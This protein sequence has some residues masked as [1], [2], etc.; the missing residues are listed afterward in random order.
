MNDE[1]KTMI[2]E[3]LE[4][5]A[6]VLRTHIGTAEDPTGEN[7]HK[8]EMSFNS[9]NGL[10]VIYYRERFATVSGGW[11]ALVGAACQA[12]DDELEASNE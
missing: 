12:I 6:L 8:I 3:V 9:M 11:Q 5:N 10:P 4:P 7:P 2:M 1:K